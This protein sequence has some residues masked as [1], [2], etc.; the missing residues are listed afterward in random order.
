VTGLGPETVISILA[1]TLLG[2]G[3]LLTLLPVGTCDQ[4]AHCRLEK[5]A[6]ER[7]RQS[8]P[9]GR[10]G[11]AAP[12]CSVCGRHHRADEDHPF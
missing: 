8:A 3:G 1:L 12:F 10:T 6:R 11:A 9:L 2:V 5:L 4:C 7:E